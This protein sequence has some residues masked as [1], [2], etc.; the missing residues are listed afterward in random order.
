MNK[1]LF[2]GMMACGAFIIITAAVGAAAAAT[3]NE[4][5]AFTVCIDK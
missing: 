2:V 4:C 5:L 3:K 1:T